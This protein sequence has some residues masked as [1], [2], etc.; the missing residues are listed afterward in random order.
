MNLLS[1]LLSRS[2]SSTDF[3]PQIL[4]HPNPDH[5]PSY[6]GVSPPP[7]QDPGFWDNGKFGVTWVIY[8]FI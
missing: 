7:S 4:L 5:N 8:R 6:P 3:I 2:W 1:T